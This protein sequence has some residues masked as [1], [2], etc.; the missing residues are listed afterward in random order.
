MELAV[1]LRLEAERARPWPG[2]LLF[3]RQ[4]KEEPAS[5][6][7]RTCEV[8]PRGGSPVAAQ[9]GC[10]QTFQPLGKRTLFAQL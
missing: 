4:R 10:R 2:R 5:G 3:E 9:K 6:R 1:E 7:R 8:A